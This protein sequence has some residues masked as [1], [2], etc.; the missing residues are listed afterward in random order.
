MISLPGGTFLSG[1]ATN[2]AQALAAREDA[3][4]VPGV[5]GVDNGLAVPEPLAPGSPP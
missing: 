3:W 4:D 1:S 5:V 2:H